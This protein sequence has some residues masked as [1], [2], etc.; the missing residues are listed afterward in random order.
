MNNI[1]SRPC[2]TR[3]VRTPRRPDASAPT[4]DG[5][6]APTS[7]TAPARPGAPQ[8]PP[9]HSTAKEVTTVPAPQQ[10][11]RPTR[12]SDVARAQ[13][14]VAD[15][16]MTEPDWN[17]V[18]QALSGF[19][20]RSVLLRAA[21][22]TA[23]AGAELHAAVQGR[24]CTAR[25]RYATYYRQYFRTESRLLHLLKAAALLGRPRGVHGEHHRTRRQLLQQ[26]SAIEAALDAQGFYKETTDEEAARGCVRIGLGLVHHLASG[27]SLPA[28]C[29]AGHDW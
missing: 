11:A 3:L 18:Q 12:T 6:P 16:S 4:P 27:A 9:V 20:W 22:R 5:R 14:S 21:L 19:S 2:Q 28:D 26:A 25:D 24:G 8:S 15:L 7:A 10:P 17:Q 13:R 29:S 1:T 23:T